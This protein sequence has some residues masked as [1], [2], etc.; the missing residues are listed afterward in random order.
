MDANQSTH[1]SAFDGSR[2]I[3]S[4]APADVAVAVRH[5]LDAGA[6]GPV[7]ILDDTSARQLEFDLRGSDQEIR[8]RLQPAPPPPR[9]AGRPR[10][11]VVAREVTLL[12]RHWDWLA[13]QPAG[14]SATLRRVVEQAMRGAVKP[15]HDRSAAEAVDRCMLALSGNLPGHE[16][17]SRAF[18]RGDRDRFAA[19][20]ADWPVDVRTYLSRLVQR[21]WG[22]ADVDADPD[23][24]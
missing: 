7:L 20:I 14:V 17:A 19:Q 3:A 6:A 16:E 1:C 11:G 21:A 12:P 13:A 18:W 15:L 2:R 8:A 24:M 22:A 4:G 9:R 23:A 5:A 10:L